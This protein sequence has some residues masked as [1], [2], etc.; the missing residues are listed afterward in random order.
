M[1]GRGFY[2]DVVTMWSL[3]SCRR[4]WSGR[5]GV[6]RRVGGRRTGSPGRVAGPGRRAGSPD[7]VAGPGRRIG[8]SD[9]AFRSKPLAPNPPRPDKHSPHAYVAT[10]ARAAAALSRFAGRVGQA[11]AV[12]GAEADRLRSAARE[13]S[14]TARSRRARQRPARRFRRCPGRSSDP[15]CRCA[16]PAPAGCRRAGRA[17][18]AARRGGG[19]GR[20][21]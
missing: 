17:D 12:T 14:P 7:Q 13:R 15:G 8:S 21:G 11:C 19:A 3:T 4:P 10:T 9:H 5:S 2:P 16:G 18:A 6:V 1:N 20:C